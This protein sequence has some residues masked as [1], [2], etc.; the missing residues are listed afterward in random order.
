MEGFTVAFL[1]FP[2]FCKSAICMA[3]GAEGLVDRWSG[4]PGGFGLRIYAVLVWQLDHFVFITC[5]IKLIN[6]FLG[7]HTP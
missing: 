1:V 5:N 2:F 7:H 4:S 6:S 3:D